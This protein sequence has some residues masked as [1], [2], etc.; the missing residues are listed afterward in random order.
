MK[1]EDLMCWGITESSGRDEESAACQDHRTG[2]CSS[3]V[4]NQK[5]PGEDRL[6]RE[7]NY[8]LFLQPRRLVRVIWLCFHQLR[9]IL[10]ERWELFKV[11]LLE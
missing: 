8:H 5:N 7:L 10:V 4:R 1:R 11:D 2:G 3:R 6:H 9:T